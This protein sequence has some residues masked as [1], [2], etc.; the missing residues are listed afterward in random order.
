MRAVLAFLFGLAVGGF[1]ACYKG[2]PGY[3]GPDYPPEPP[4]MSVS[5]CDAG[6]G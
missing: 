6:T 3:G 2:D 4:I 1:V 5:A